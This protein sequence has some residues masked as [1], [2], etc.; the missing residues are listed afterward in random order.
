MKKFCLFVVLL[1][2]VFMSCKNSKKEVFE[3]SEDYFDTIRKVTIHAIPE[4]LLAD[5]SDSI[6]S[7]YKLFENHE[8]WVDREN[9]E[10]LI[11]QI[12]KTKDEGLNPEDYNINKIFRLEL[13][14]DSLQVE[15]KLAYDILLTQTYEKLC[16][17]YY[18][19]KLNPDEVYDN[20]DLFDK[21]LSIAKLLKEAI[22]TKKIAP[23]IKGLLPTHPIY[24]SLK[25]ALVEVDKLPASK[26]DS[27][28]INLKI[29]FNDNSEVIKKIKQRLVIGKI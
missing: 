13:R 7:F 9:R 26:F 22:D 8:I 1:F 16:N 11:S 14:M 2:V 27:I 18:R 28:D 24:L 25:G 12:E 3:E 21:K 20:W 15:E 19:G 5:K 23:S 6:R 17:H 4:D 29:K 10:D